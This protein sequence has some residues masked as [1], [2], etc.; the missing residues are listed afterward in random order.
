LNRLEAR[1]REAS[2]SVWAREWSSSRRRLRAS[3]CEAAALLRS[4][5]L[6]TAADAGD[7]AGAPGATAAERGEAVPVRGLAS[8]E[9]LDDL[10]LGAGFGE[11]EDPGEERKLRP[12]AVGVDGD[13]DDGEEG[14]ARA[15]ARADGGGGAGCGWAGCGERR[16]RVWMGVYAACFLEKSLILLFYSATPRNGIFS[17]S[18][19]IST[20]DEG[21]FG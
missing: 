13:D 9:R 6:E 11:A 18:R 10:D 16:V 20:K 8:G 2:R 17:S 3:I 4:P 12:A 7:G 14:P 21:F 19:C 1:E 15:R 5:T